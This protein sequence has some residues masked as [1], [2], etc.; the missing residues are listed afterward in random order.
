MG[1]KES[2]QGG[3][4]DALF[5]RVQQ[6]VL[7]ILFSHPQESFLVT[8]VIRLAGVGTG[9]VHRE[10]GRLYGA[11]LLTV[12]TA[13]R[14]KAYQ[15]NPDS[16]IF[17]E[18]RGLVLKTVG[19]AQPLR[20]ALLPLRERILAAFVYGSVAKG[21]DTA[22]S[23]IDLMIIA[24]DVTYAEVYGLL[25]AAESAIGRR[26]TPNILTPEQWR[27]RQADAQH[28]VHALAAQPKIFLLGSDADIA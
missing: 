24:E 16:P 7:G 11:G 12:S 23:D 21:S 15:A 20:E 5:T 2:P 22:Q 8:E 18:L 4:A 28:F 9:A 26:V 27:T 3:L 6:R 17:A 10:L 1:R 13:G 19:L 25:E 14:Q